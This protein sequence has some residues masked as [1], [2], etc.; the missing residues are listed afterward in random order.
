MNNGGN[1]LDKNTI[2]SLNMDPKSI[3]LHKMALSKMKNIRVDPTAKHDF[4]KDRIRAKNISNIDDLYSKLNDLEKNGA[5]DIWIN[6]FG[7]K[8]Y[9]IGGN[10]SIKESDVLSA[11]SKIES[12]I[13]TTLQEME[14]MEAGVTGT[15]HAAASG[16]VA[17]STNA[18]IAY[19]NG[20]GKNKHLVNRNPEGTHQD[21]NLGGN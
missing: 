13:E 5:L 19:M 14:G 21:T 20:P 17:S 2:L 10:T 11:S 15:G 1:S 7:K 6:K 16:T 9:M 12:L 4:V 3:D 18:P 8:K